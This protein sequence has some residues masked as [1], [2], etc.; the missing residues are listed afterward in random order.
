MVLQRT[1]TRTYKIP[2]TEVILNK[3]TRVLIPVAGYNYD[4]DIYK[5]PNTFNPYRYLERNANDMIH[6]HF[7]AGPRQCIGDKH[8]QK[9]T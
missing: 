3:G 7:G 8:K 9:F 2:G 1:C 5:E 6:L 4:S